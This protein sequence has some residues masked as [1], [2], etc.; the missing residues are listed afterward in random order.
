ME[1]AE[2]L[3]GADFT[4]VRFAFHS[5]YCQSEIVEEPFRKENDGYYGSYK[6]DKMEKHGLGYSY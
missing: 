4:N 6:S 3:K 1:A 5:R 2:A